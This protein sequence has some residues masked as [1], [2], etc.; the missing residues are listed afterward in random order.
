MDTLELPDIQGIIVRG[1][2]MPT[3]RYYL[4]KVGTPSAAR[5][6][7]GRLTSGDEADA[8][9]VTSAEEWHVATA[10]PH[11]DPTRS[12]RWKPD[13]CLNV[14][15][16]WP[17]LVAMGVA[18]R[19]PPPRS[20]SFDA[21][22]EG[23]AP[24]AG[25]LG[26]DGDS[27]PEH[28]VGGFGTGDDHVMV[29]L[30]ALTPEVREDYSRRLT[31]L[32]QEQDAFEVLWHHDGAAMVE[33]VDGEPVPVPKTHFGYTDGIT[34]TPPILGGPEPVAPDHQ[35]AC[36]PWLFVL[37]EDADSYQLP[38]P[39]ELWRN[40]S[41]GV[42]KM[43]EQDVVGFEDFLQANKDQIDPELLA[44][45]IC[46][47]W[48]NGVPLAL[49]PDTDSP[50]GGIT[51]EQLNDF[52]YVN[53]DGSGDPQGLRCP[54]GAHIRRVNPRGQPVQGQG[55]PGGSNNA[56]RV[57]RRGMPY[58]PVYDPSVPHDGVE[59]GLLGYF[60]NAY[61][62][63]QYEFV[64]KEWVESGS[65]AGRVRLNPG[66][67]D[68]LVGANDP[69]ASV[70]E[71]P[72]D[73]GPPLK[74][75]GFSR[76]I[77]TKAAAYCF[78]PSLSALR[79]IAGVPHEELR[80]SAS[81]TS[82]ASSAQQQYEAALAQVTVDSFRGAPASAKQDTLWELISSSPYATLPSAVVTNSQTV[83]RLA[84]RAFL[85]EAFEQDDDVRPPRAKAFHTYGTVGKMR[86]E[87]DGEHPFTGIFDTGAVG[88]V[89]ASLAVG[90]PGYS[91]AAAFKFLIDG[92]HPS[93][94]LLV[95]QSLDKQASRD[96]FERAATNHT[97]APTMFPNTAMLPLLRLWLSR[98]S[99][100]IEL[101]RLDHLA[102]TTNDGTAVE[103]PCA[104]ELVYL[105]GTDEVRNDPASTADFREILAQIPAGTPLYRMYGKASATA[106]KV[107]VGTI[108]L[109]SPFVASEFGDHVLAF[110]HAW[111]VTGACPG[112]KQ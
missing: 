21:F 105:Y 20:G 89:R 39:H 83:R 47:R 58:G 44:A 68:A 52:E 57:I 100:P 71:I 29:A 73:G 40:G 109:E 16:T 90:M 80:T 18:D 62:E 103:R 30:Y 56:H 46:G 35:E 7:L 82:D 8:P 79:W 96:F 50:P 19:I 81:S 5:A 17:G 93:Q 1:Y 108:T 53:S 27:G 13:Y 41:F 98:I 101:Q 3:V 75:T 4:L 43:M 91:P 78:L 74:V 84:K 51:E 67:K 66:S 22:V 77:T 11:D 2:R 24:R 87:A 9:Q 107:Y 28:W 32:F 76:F 85:R 102:V 26:D 70:F 61:I 33:M 15:V 49:S 110:Q 94:N 55:S 37:S 38:S 10:G 25:R 104:P 6:V 95:H 106:E 69:A 60:I 34:M 88:F 86:F 65:F 72:Q 31:A 48:R 99:S 97:L 54:V 42:F 36:E 92:P 12:P 112:A 64:L 111:P 23:A 14:G 63:N 45:K 59:R